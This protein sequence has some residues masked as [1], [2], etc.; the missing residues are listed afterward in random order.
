MT[1]KRHNQDQEGYFILFE[2][3]LSWRMLRSIERGGILRVAEA[4]RNAR[5]LAAFTMRYRG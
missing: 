1:M 5:E 3:A 4:D 2:K